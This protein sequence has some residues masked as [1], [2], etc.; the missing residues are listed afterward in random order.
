MLLLMVLNIF[1]FWQQDSIKYQQGIEYT[2]IICCH[3]KQTRNDNI[4]QCS[5]WLHKVR[6]DWKTMA[7]MK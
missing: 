3:M 2:V 7:K 5:Q 4:S 1:F 6:G